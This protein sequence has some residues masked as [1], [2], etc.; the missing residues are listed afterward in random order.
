MNGQFDKQVERVRK[1]LNGLVDDYVD[2]VGDCEDEISIYSSGR[3]RAKD[4]M[5]YLEQ[6]YLKD[7]EQK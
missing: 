3:D 7:P 2:Q 5:T 6:T 1:F 4:F